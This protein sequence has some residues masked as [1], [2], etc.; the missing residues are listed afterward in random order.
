MIT[1]R[2][3]PYN[4]NAALDIIE[5]L[6]AAD[7]GKKLEAKEW[8]EFE[9]EEYELRYARLAALMKIEGIDAALFTQ[10]E[11]VRYFSGYLTVLWISRF[12]P[13][14]ALLPADT[15]RSSSVLTSGQEVGNLNGTSWVED[16]RSFSPQVPPIPYMAG[17]IKDILPEG[18]KIGIEIGFG[19]RLGMNIEQLLE[20][21]GMLPDVEFVDITPLAETVRMLKS[22]AEIAFIT[23]A[24]RIS[25]DAVAKGWESVK[26]GGNERAVLAVMAAEMYGQGAEVSGTKQSVFGIMSGER[27]ALSNAVATDKRSF[28]EGDMMMIDGGATYHGYVTDFIR[29]L[30]IGPVDALTQ[31]WFDVAIEAN[32]AAIAAIKP[33]VLAS[34]VYDAAMAIF[35]AHDLFKYN[36]STIVG[37]GI[38]ADIHELPW[39]GEAGTVYTSDTTLRE[40][41]VLSIEPIIASSADDA[42][43]G[44]FIVEDM[45]VVTATG[46]EIITGT[47]STE[48]WIAP[49]S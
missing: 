24:A 41:M 5:P 14:V 6:T 37:H 44:H 45:V 1:P 12:R 33:G 18:G 32:S 13:F 31:K 7:L 16:P 35:K 38:G 39:L 36:K 46:A 48:L 22:A 26:V 25:C 9:P 49:V 34:D 17:M 2:T 3:T 8:A 42:P 40:G 30:S 20:L 47:I 19:Q 21:E 15:T 27:L 43:F 28:V 10:E 4:F 11:N 23:E 29:Q